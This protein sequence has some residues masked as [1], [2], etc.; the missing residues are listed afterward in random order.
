V[1]RDKS[2]VTRKNINHENMRETWNSEQGK[3]KAKSFLITKPRKNE[4]TKS[5]GNGLGKT[6]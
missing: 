2:Q 5:R 3:P 4:N 6:D 1:T